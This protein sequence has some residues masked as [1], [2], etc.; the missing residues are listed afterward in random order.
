M[1]AKLLNIGLILTSLI[2]Y[3]EWGTDQSMFLFQGEWDVLTKLFTEI[4]AM[5]LVEE[6]AP[7]HQ[8]LLQQFQ[9]GKS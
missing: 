2:G 6:K 7:S 9:Y 5:K 3:L 4:V 8:T 1:K